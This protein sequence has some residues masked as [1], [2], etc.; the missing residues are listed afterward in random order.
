MRRSRPSLT[1][2]IASLVCA[3]LAVLP[4]DVPTTGNPAVPTVAIVPFESIGSGPNQA[5]LVA[6]LMEDLRI[7]LSEETGLRVIS[8]EIAV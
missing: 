7:T 6:G 4:S 1:T 3:I 2:F 8:E 5:E